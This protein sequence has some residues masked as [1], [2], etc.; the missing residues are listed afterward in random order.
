MTEKHCFKSLAGDNSAP[1]QSK[2]S[3]SKYKGDS[4]PLTS[5]LKG[6]NKIVRRSRDVY[7]R[8][9]WYMRDKRR[10]EFYRQDIHVSDRPV[11]R[12]IYKE[13]IQDWIWSDVVPQYHTKQTKST[14]CVEV[15]TKPKKR[16]NIYVQQQ[17]GSCVDSY[18][19]IFDLFPQ[20]TNDK[21][22]CLIES[23]GIL[24][25]QL[26]R[27]RSLPDCLC[28]II[29][30]LKGNIDTSLAQ[31][32]GDHSV[33]NI[34]ETLYNDDEPSLVEDPFI[35]DIDEKY[36][37]EIEMVEQSGLTL[38][39]FSAG[40]KKAR[41]FVDKTKRITVCPLTKKLNRILIF[42][43]AITAYQHHNVSIGKQ[44]VVTIDKELYSSGLMLH[45]DAIHSILDLI[46]FLCEKGLQIATTGNV[47]CIF[48]S[49]S[50]YE[51]W[52]EE[53]VKLVA[54]SKYLSNPKPHGIDIHTYNQ[55]VRVLLEK[56]K[57]I[58]KYACE[59]D[60]R[61]K[62][63]VR[64]MCLQL[65]N[66]I[67]IC[68]NQRCAREV[69]RAP[70]AIILEGDTGVGKTTFADL[71][72]IYYGSLREK[73]ISLGNRYMR[74]AGAKFWDGFASHQWSLLL[75]DVAFA[76]PANTTDMDP[77]LSELIQIINNAPYCPDKAS[78]EEKGNA[79][80]QCE[81][82]TLTTNSPKMHL[83]HYYAVPSAA[84]RRTPYHIR[85]SV[86]PEFCMDDSHMLNP[87]KV[88]PCI[89]GEY[90]DI[91]QIDIYD[92]VLG[93][94]VQ[95]DTDHP[96][97]RSY[98][99]VKKHS[100]DM[101]GFLKWYSV[102][103]R[104]HNE[105]QDKIVDS[106]AI[107]RQTKIC[108]TCDLP[109]SFCKCAVNDVYMPLNEPVEQMGKEIVTWSITYLCRSLFMSLI[110]QFI[111]S[112]LASFTSECIG[113]AKYIY[114]KHRVSMLW[115]KCMSKTSQVGSFIGTLPKYA[116][117]YV[118]SR[119]FTHIVADYGKLIGDLGRQVYNSYKPSPFLLTLLAAATACIAAIMC[120]KACSPVYGEQGGLISK[121]V[122][123]KGAE[124][125]SVWYNDHYDVSHFDL[126]R[127]SLSW[128][129]LSRE[130][131]IKQLSKSILK[132]RARC[133]NDTEWT[134]FVVLAIGGQRYLTNSHCIPKNGPVIVQFYTRGLMGV[135]VNT[136]FTL[137]QSEIERR[138]NDICCF[139]VKRL[140]PTRDLVDMFLRKDAD[141]FSGDAILLTRHVD[142]H[143]QTR[144]VRGV[145]KRT[146][147]INQQDG[148]F[149]GGIVPEPTT[150]GD[151]GSVMV[152][153]TNYG[154]VIA[155]IHS[156]FDEIHNW[157][158]SRV[159]YH[160]DFFEKEFVPAPPML[161][162][163]ISTKGELGELHSKSPVR[164]IEKGTA[165]VYGSFTGFRRKH[166]SDVVKSIV[167]ESMIN[168]GYTL[169]YGKPIMSGW[170]PWHRHLSAAVSHVAHIDNEFLLKCGEAMFQDWMQGC[171]KSDLES[172]CVYDMF[173]AV[174]GAP[175][176]RFVDAIN[177]K[178]SAGYPWSKSK[179][180][181]LLPDESEPEMP[182]AQQVDDSV[183]N[184]VREIEER[185]RNR[186]R[187]MPVFTASL[188][189]EAR[190]FSKISDK[191]TRI[192][193]GSP[194]DFSLVMRK[195]LLSC[196]RLIQRK[197]YVFEAAP[198]TEAQ[199][200][201]WDS[202]YHYLTQFGANTVIAGDFKDYDI[203]LM[204]E[205]LLLCFDL[206]IRLH[207]VA[208][209]DDHHL[210][211]LEGIKFDVCF[212]LVEYNGDLIEF[213]GI[214]PSG[215]ALTT[216]LNSLANSLLMRYCYMDNNP[217]QECVTF[218]ENVAL[219]TYGD[220]N[221]Q[222]V[223]TTCSW[224]NHTSIQKTL[225][226]IGITYTMAEKGAESVPYIHID[227]ASFLKRTWRFEAELNRRVCPLEMDSIIK[228]LMIGVKSKFLSDSAQMIEVMY[229]A[230]DEF[231]WHGA[232]IFKKYQNL[233]M[234]LVDEHDLIVYMHK[235]FPT[236]EELKLRY[237]QNSE[238]FERDPVVDKFTQQSG[239]DVFKCERC[240][241]STCSISVTDMETRLCSFCLHCRFDTYDCDC[242]HC[243]ENDQ[244][245]MCG[246]ISS[247][248]AESSQSNMYG[249]KPWVCLTCELIRCKEPD[250]IEQSGSDSMSIIE[251][252]YEDYVSAQT[253]SVRAPFVYSLL[254]SMIL[255]A[256]LG[257][258]C[259]FLLFILVVMDKTYGISILLLLSGVVIVNF[260]SLVSYSNIVINVTFC[261]L[262]IVWIYIVKPLVQIVSVYLMVDENYLLLSMGPVTPYFVRNTQEN[263]HEVITPQKSD[264]CR[265][266]EQY[267]QE[268]GQSLFDQMNLVQQSG[269]ESVESSSRVDNSVGVSVV[270]E[271]AT[272]MD[273]NE[274][275]IFKFADDDAS[276]VN[277]DM[278]TNIDLGNFLSRP[279]LIHTISWVEGGFAATSIDP[280][281]LFLNSTPIKSKLNNFA[282]LRG[283]LRVKIVVNASPFYYGAM[284]FGYTPTSY[285]T[286]IPAVA[287]YLV[288]WSQRPHVFVYPKESS[289]AEMTLPFLW[290]RGYVNITSAASV[291]ALGSL[292]IIEFSALQSANGATTNG[293]TI[294][295]YAWME[296][297]TLTAATAGL[298]MQSG[299]EYDTSGVISGP[300]TAVAKV[301]SY[302][303]KI[304]VI[305]RFALATEIG[306]RAIAGMAS[307]FGWT[308]VI[309]CEGVRPVKNLP[310]H[311][312]ASAHIS[313]CGTKFSLDPKAEVSV[314]P[315]ILGCP[316]IDELSIASI[317][318]RDS[319]LCKSTWATTDAV[320]QLKFSSMVTP[321]IYDRGTGG[322]TATYCI[323]NT[324]MSH[325]GQ[326][327]RNWRGDIIFRFKIICSQFHRGRL[328][329][330]W[331][332]VSSITATTDYTN[333]AFTKVVDL[334]E[335][336]E[337]EFRV[338]YMQSLAWCT[339]GD[340]HADNVWSTSTA[341][342]PN[343]DYVNGTLTLR[344]LTN[345]SAP[346]DTASVDILTFVRAA[347]NLEF[348][349]PRDV[350]DKYS[351]FAIQ[352]GSE[353]VESE[354]HQTASEPFVQGRSPMSELYLVNYGEAIPSM[355]LLLRR[356]TMVD[357][358]ILSYVSSFVSTDKVGRF[359]VVQTRMPATPG[360][361]TKAY[362]EQYGIIS[363]L[364]HYRF[365]YCHMTP[366]TWLAP[367]YAAYRGS[368]RWKYNLDNTGNQVP[369]NIRVTRNLGSV[370]ANNA[371]QEGLYETVMDE[372]TTI[373]SIV[374]TNLRVYDHTRG[375]S[376]MFLTNP[377]TQAG[378]NVEMPYMTKYRYSYANPD[379][380]LVGSSVDGTDEDTYHIDVLVH[381]AS[382]N[383]GQMML[384]R[385]V[386]IGT[387]FNLYMY[388][389]APM[390][391]YNNG[392]GNH[393]YPLP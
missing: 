242:P 193:M 359:T 21:L 296:N 197:K 91:W 148:V 388:L 230:N 161:D 345:L 192:F 165:A 74:V 59:L 204:A 220:D 129:S 139:S 109:T 227:Q 137:Q 253:F 258:F 351:F 125:E 334:G 24:G 275:E 7:D 185:Y 381:P 22:W 326:C 94:L 168:R 134:T 2:S 116:Y 186:E 228:S 322:I 243:C 313:D 287:N 231:F 226:K 35:D 373:P 173:T 128:K 366:L 303:G 314:D 179:R 236:W 217:E 199:S 114:V 171:T 307:L 63:A 372:D 141:V 360:Y 304:P 48:H 95:G 178:S 84:A 285:V 222:N 1:A 393:P 11:G 97:K 260:K 205:I 190:K 188:K 149:M 338:P 79:P 361:D 215:Q 342:S 100:L 177:K 290:H 175:G 317:V 47:E 182:H 377:D 281:T 356:S 62:S 135:S 194:L 67:H 20:Y 38:E 23:L 37:R 374:K 229:S 26:Y 390:V 6:Y 189:D 316:N 284:F 324:P 98:S 291:A 235:P 369:Q 174:N 126:G 277:S 164:Y 187:A 328:R 56:G 225:S 340:I 283:N 302:L 29:S 320:G 216:I 122:R 130:N 349:N 209:C 196:I 343:Q 118:R 65:Q 278:L 387:D 352:S 9:L 218:K 88:K 202:F 392:L 310:F 382:G 66:V 92:T 50:S 237:I 353:P 354:K 33:M 207:K 4:T 297:V 176:V 357:Q 305:G 51:T 46:V 163:K 224:Y 167:C 223:N 333:V 159:V 266:V 391:Y 30:F 255:G 379:N 315:S 77:T 172:L 264:E 54:Q 384:Q 239:K 102:L 180:Y 93:D 292:K 40:V 132:G 348:A 346:I 103:I 105:N 32:I 247:V 288:P 3:P 365:S 254:Q 44:F 140:P 166:K 18:Q 262:Y 151:C 312:M 195:N 208:G 86:K 232:D 280:W 68:I 210:L 380:F 383:L 169:N 53:A 83:S 246:E 308:N 89:I 249:Y 301:A 238:R 72:H 41:D 104:S 117:E 142:G 106:S 364:N 368:I 257:I 323:A 274:S 350:N 371:R 306:A 61:S 265:P 219:L 160:E 299:T 8:K 71:V 13:K 112:I 34:V 155:G 14:K 339:L 110:L 144:E 119:A 5:P 321:N 156:V 261:A 123:P 269:V 213:F 60:H 39:S 311:D 73:D 294:Q 273:A 58:Y 270:S 154:P 152:L 69:R 81:L 45:A 252:L 251:I 319:Y 259:V 138:S 99:L 150:L 115:L 367:C 52:Y 376:G 276:T 143:L 111:L 101:I 183:L 158:G 331:D 70:L 211:M 335:T 245:E 78:L 295:V 241:F 240:T 76:N 268:R 19:S 64:G 108:S 358:L 385:F 87:K 203:S 191:N 55:Q 286:A 49:E 12:W 27:S 201:E 36:V 17:S 267:I 298:A 341:Q 300:A 153:L 28:A 16:R 133:K 146:I 279:T 214:N 181:L 344:V 212:S 272:F 250:W 85:L 386:S 256:L 282:Y 31:F 96:F 327:F 234:E 82:V 355:R 131:L 198:G 113:M 233:L 329:I 75:D 120:Y 293:C 375:A 289:G 271:T 42:V 325:L 318:Q 136:E 121:E 337:V 244:C 370:Y 330:T 362:Y 347:D 206:L 263:N 147:P 170:E 124:R 332:P 127:R 10:K 57:C 43:T 248:V 200:S 184:R 221:V 309:N 107:L 363:G 162:S 25:F 336:D 157:A 80:L 389:N 90:P 15:H 145:R 378:I